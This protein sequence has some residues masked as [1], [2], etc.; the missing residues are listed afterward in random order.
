MFSSALV[1]IVGCVS[2]SQCHSS[3][4]LPFSSCTIYS[5]S[6]VIYDKLVKCLNVFIQYIFKLTTEAEAYAIFGKV[7]VFFCELYRQ[8]SP[9]YL[10]EPCITNHNN[11]LILCIISD[12]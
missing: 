7:K 10:G 12:D 2:F 11:I 8:S 6:L 1:L 3:S 5:I 9:F 4:T